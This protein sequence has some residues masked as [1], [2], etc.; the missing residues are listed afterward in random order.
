[1]AQVILKLC[2]NKHFYDSNQYK[3]GCPYCLNQTVPT[4]QL[5][6][7]AQNNTINNNNAIP[8]PVS[9]SSFSYTVPSDITDDLTAYNGKESYAFC[10]YS[11]KDSQ[12]VLPVIKN[13]QD[14]YYRVWYDN[15]IKSG[16]SW[17]KEIAIKIKECSQF[18]VFLSPN[19]IESENVKNEIYSALKHNKNMI[20]IYLTNF[21]LDDELDLMLG[22]KH[23]IKYSNSESFYKLLKRELSSDL[24]FSMVNTQEQDSEARNDILKN[25]V[26]GN[27]IGKGSFATVYEAK[28]KKTNCKVAIKHFVYSSKIDSHRLIIEGLRHEIDA[29]AIL[30]SCPYTPN[31]I[32]LYEDKNNIYV[33]QS[34]LE[35][36]TLKQLVPYLNESSVVSIA[37][38]IAYI[39]QQLYDTS[40][41]KPMIIHN[42]IKPS[43]IILTKYKDVILTDFNAAKIGENGKDYH[44][45][46]I[47]YAAPERIHNGQDGTPSTDIFSLGRT[48]HYLLTNEMELSQ[49]GQLPIRV[50]NPNISS[51]LESI[52]A[53]MTDPNPNLR[54]SSIEAVIDLLENHQ[55]TLENVTV[56][57][58][59][60]PSYRVEK[61]EAPENKKKNH[62]QYFFFKKKKNFEQANTQNNI[63]KFNSNIPT[64]F[65]NPNVLPP[66]KRDETEQIYEDTTILYFGNP[67]QL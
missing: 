31:I 65:P 53:K 27:M 56:N 13:L 24:I 25:Y 66:V 34:Y 38:K 30:S 47:G 3:S 54:I 51:N 58:A 45:G 14:D 46:T 2:N 50:L 11:H 21:E 64:P 61:F 12:I 29:L 41:K 26:L 32:D 23:A 44:L 48:M 49:T 9:H 57:P 39:L 59:P 60:A 63:P 6:F 67:N 37:L 10:S 35:G 62:F 33:V 7:S 4:S 18:I 43:N 19:A 20:I 42:D 28:N 55:N 40:D 5:N 15:G 16:T 36:K 8:F 52:I 17:G 22:R 1:M